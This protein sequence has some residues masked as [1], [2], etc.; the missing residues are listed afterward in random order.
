[1]IIKNNNVVLTKQILKSRSFLTKFYNKIKHKNIVLFPLIEIMPLDNYS[2][3]LDKIS[4]LETF[5]IVFF[6]S[7][8]A[9]TF[10][11]KRVK[12]WPKQVKIGVFGF[13]SLKTLEKFGINYL[14]FSL[15][16]PKE[17]FNSGTESLLSQ[18]KFTEIKDKKIL[19]INAGG[20]RE[21]LSKTM[22]SQGVLVEEVAS[23]KRCFTQI[24]NERKIYF[25]K[26]LQKKCIWVV[27]SSEI[28]NYLL[29]CSNNIAGNRGILKIL[30]S[31]LIV[32]HERIVY[33]ARK[34][35]FKKILLI[36]PGDDALF[37]AIQYEYE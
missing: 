8:N 7:P 18:I 29:K 21:L 25:E 17:N 9:I 24:E 19:I 37:D 26:L 4:K 34:I 6:S 28:V 16:H 27:S 33:S 32:Q 5:E 2:K 31:I 11:L 23:Y 36:E 10:T 15:I 20:G 13:E 12:N 3:L 1:M 35:G 14:N 22:E 30:E